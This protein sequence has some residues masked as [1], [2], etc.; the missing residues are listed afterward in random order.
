MSAPTSL[1]FS[2]AS[3]REITPDWLLVSPSIAPSEP[4]EGLIQKAL[5]EAHLKNRY[6]ILSLQCDIESVLGREALVVTFQLG[7]KSL[8]CTPFFMLKASEFDA[9]IAQP[10]TPL[11]TDDFSSLAEQ[12]SA[13]VLCFDQPL[14][15]ETVAIPK[16]WGQEIWYTGVEERGVCHVKGQGAKQC[17]PLPWLL[18]LFPQSFSAGQDQLVLLKILDPRPEPVYGD[19]YFELHEKKQEVYVVTHIDKNAWPDGKGGI[20]FGFCPK[21]REQYPS[22]DAF[23]T[24]YEK[25]VNAYRQVRV[26]IDALYDQKR[27]SEGFGLNDA[28]GYDVIAPWETDLPE[29]LREQESQLRAQMESFT[30][31]K[32]LKLGDVV[33]VPCFLPHS[34]QHGV[35]TIEFQTPVYERKILSFAQ[36]VLTQEHWDTHDALKLASV[37]PAQDSDLAVLSETDSL[38]QESVVEFDDFSVKRL[39]L[40]AKSQIELTNDAYTLVIGIEQTLQCDGMAVKP[41]QAVII[42]SCK[43]AFLVENCSDS[44]A[45]FLIANPAL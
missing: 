21:K 14:S 28:L 9:R 44:N 30:H 22:D 29:L 31:L 27:L 25:A 40:S 2:V 13:S 20:R 26:E 45:V 8:S 6:R 17:I 42:P 32:S 41:E 5:Q 36:K 43:D 39:T 34:L 35:R 24:D 4:I 19:L 11:L 12:F 33:K 1:P 3:Q 18:V 10:S 7:N 38:K 16:P 15:L 37:K 23:L